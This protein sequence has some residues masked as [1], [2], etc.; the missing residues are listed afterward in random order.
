MLSVSLSRTQSKASTATP[1]ESAFR[2]GS[3]SPMVSATT[4]MTALP[5][6]PTISLI[7]SM[8]ES[9]QPSIL[10][11]GLVDVSTAPGSTMESE[12]Y[13]AFPLVIK[14]GFRIK[15]AGV[16]L[17]SFLDVLCAMREVLGASLE[18]GYSIPENRT[19]SIAITS[20]QDRR[21]IFREVPAIV[22]CQSE[23][24]G[25]RLL[26]ETN[27]TV[28][29]VCAPSRLYQV[30]RCSSELT[31]NAAM[32]ADIVVEFTIKGGVPFC[33][34]TQ[35]SADDAVLAIASP[36]KP[37]LVTR[38]AE[39]ETSIEGMW[40]ASAFELLD[41]SVYSSK[42]NMCA[43]MEGP[44]H[45]E[46]AK[47]GSS[48]ASI[49]GGI[50]ASFVVVALLIL[51]AVMSHRRRRTR[52]K[53]QKESGD[54]IETLESAE[55]SWGTAPGAAVGRVERFAGV[56][57][58]NDAGVTR[59]HTGV[60]SSQIS[61]GGGPIV[62]AQKS[63]V[64]FLHNL[65]PQ[66]QIA[67][68]IPDFIPIRPA[69]NRAQF[70]P[71]GPGHAERV[72]FDA[73]E[74]VGTVI[75]RP[76]PPQLQNATGSRSS[77]TDGDDFR[78]E[79]S[80]PATGKRPFAPEFHGSQSI[81]QPS[82]HDFYS[83]RPD[84]PLTA[85]T[86]RPFAPFA[87]V[88]GAQPQVGDHIPGALQSSSGYTAKSN[89]ARAARQ[90]RTF[91]ALDI[92]SLREQARSLGVHDNRRSAALVVRNLAGGVLT[93]EPSIEETQLEAIE[94][95]KPKGLLDTFKVFS[96]QAPGDSLARR[97]SMRV[98][99]RSFV[100]SAPSFTS[101]DESLASGG[102]GESDENF[103]NP[104]AGL[105][106]ESITRLSFNGSTVSG[107]DSRSGTAP[108]SPSLTA[109]APESPLVRVNSQGSRGST[110]SRRSRVRAAHG[111]S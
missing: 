53:P 18:L 19:K 73:I 94:G 45:T 95:A 106:S 63:R 98:Q 100:T 5:V 44:V 12:S 68:A 16:S 34:V 62:S 15:K 55:I 88:P 7:P 52:G 17:D 81:M 79:Q 109:S 30:Y 104:L 72:S 82:G 91:K 86:K 9:R 54:I 23:A 110:D 69:S 83:H 3:E 29:A 11:V 14:F 56:S 103:I 61:A 20:I 58:N 2:M 108:S 90:T 89:A 93:H 10:S 107:S 59:F 1:T 77:P 111:R 64:N 38:V 87:D 24:A 36:V 37:V 66:S 96:H 26:V 74:R 51:V 70:R 71:T 101:T 84:G 57:A 60:V 85:V 47:A 65:S 75:P 102:V 78:T 80:H 50:V 41:S 39:N 8:S 49:A 32:A 6:S 99:H 4:L 21:R 25:H 46:S 42:E 27:S 92:D 33:G 13:V 28:S 97:M 76:A 35:I 67:T 22:T 43:L 105:D 48:I 31:M 40:A